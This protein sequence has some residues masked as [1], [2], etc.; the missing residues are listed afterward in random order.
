MWKKGS[1]LFSLTAAAILSGAPTRAEY[2]VNRI[3]KIQPVFQEPT[4][5]PG[6]DSPGQPT[7]PHHG[8]D[9]PSAELIR[10]HEKAAKQFES[11]N[12]NNPLSHDFKAGGEGGLGMPQGV[13]AQKLNAL[14][15][16]PMLQGYM[17]LLS[18]P[19]FTENIK[20]IMNHPN[21]VTLFFAE[22]AWIVVMIVVRAWRFSLVSHWTRKVWVNIWTM[23]LFWGGSS[24][25]VPTVVL[26]DIYLNTLTMV[27][28]SLAKPK[29]TGAH[30]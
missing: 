8:D 28:D 10:A 4:Q 9:D 7:P 17:K 18:N 14:M 1:F 20:K 24:V 2:P 27:Y 26:G 6:S 12:A 13:A 23:V 5:Q 19:G 25:V 30:K 22:L 11:F 29:E 16:N 21:R 3:G 15:T